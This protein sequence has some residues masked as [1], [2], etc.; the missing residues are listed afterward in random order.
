MLSALSQDTGLDEVA[1]DVKE[2][3]IEMV[4]EA[5]YITTRTRNS[6]R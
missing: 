4:N 5:K 1:N 2:K 3:T 6:F